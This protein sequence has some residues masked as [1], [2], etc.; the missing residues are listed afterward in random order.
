MNEYS[1]DDDFVVW[2]KPTKSSLGLHAANRPSHSHHFN[3]RYIPI[4][5]ISYK[6]D[7]SL[8]FASLNFDSMRD[9]SIIGR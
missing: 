6:I 7:I 9:M 4:H 3:H 1:N 2:F 5:T 8:S